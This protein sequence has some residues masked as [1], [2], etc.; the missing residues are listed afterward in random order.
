[1]V[2][3]AEDGRETSLIC[4]FRFEAGKGRIGDERRA[5]LEAFAGAIASVLPRSKLVVSIGALY[6]EPGQAG[7]EGEVA[8]RSLGVA[9]DIRAQVLQKVVPRKAQEQVSRRIY[10]YCRRA[11]ASD[12]RNVAEAKAADGVLRIGVS[13]PRSHQEKAGSQE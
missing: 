10:S 13:E 2:Q 8:L 1:M 7:D 3:V 9:E 12:V 6:P 4:G 5:S 11:T